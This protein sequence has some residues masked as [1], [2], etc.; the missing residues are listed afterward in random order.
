MNTPKFLSYTKT[1]EW[2]LFTDEGTA[3]I[4][5]SDHAQEALGGI[6]FVNL[7][8]AD[9]SVSAGESFAEV[10]SVKAVSDVNSPVSGRVINVNERLLDSPE[11][12]NDDPYGSWF[13]EIAD[14]QAGDGLLTAEEY[15]EF[16]RQEG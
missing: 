13:A 5:I 10:E 3:K 4:G 6:V 9:D 7:P 11:E 12:I 16:C 1:H 8:L 2:V 14:A 15:E